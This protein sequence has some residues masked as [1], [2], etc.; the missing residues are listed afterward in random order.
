LLE[1]L[2]DRTMPSVTI[3]PTNNN[4]KGYTG[5]DYN[6]SGGYVPPDTQGAA[7]PSNYVETV[8]QT[9]A[10][11]SPKATGTTEVS[12]PLATFFASLPPVDGFGSYSDPVVTYDDN[13][14]GPAA[15]NGRF[16]IGDQNI[17][18]G[19]GAGVFDIAISKSSSPTT[20]T[21]TDWAFYQITTTE[22]NYFNDYPGN[23]GF[24]NDA[25]VFTLNMFSLTG[26]ANH[27]EVNAVSINDLLSG[28]PQNQLHHTQT[29]V[30]DFSL[31]PATEHNAAAGAPEWLI[32]QT[33]DGG[34]INVYKMQ[35]LLTTPSFSLTKLAVN[36]Y[37][38]VVNYPPLQP[39][40][41][42]ITTNIDSRIQKA[43]LEGN[44]LVATHPV[45]LSST[46][47][48]AQWYQIDVSSGTPSLH[49][50]GDVTLGNNTYAYY[51]AIDINPAGNIGM[52]FM[53]SGTGSGQYMSVYVTGRTSSDAT[54]TMETPVLVPAGT[55]QANYHDFSSTGRG[56]DLGG[57][58]IDPND[59]SFWATNEFA[60]TESTA[61][62]GTA[63]A[64]FSL[65]SALPTADLSVTNIGPSQVTAGKSSTYTITLAN[66]GPNTA[67]SL[68]L[69]D[70][71]P[72][73]GS[74]VSITPQAGNQDTFTLAQN[75]N[76]V[77]E[78]ATSVPSGHSDSFVLVVAVAS[79]LSNGSAFDDTASVSSNNSDPTPGDNTSTVNSTVVNNTQQADLG[80][81]DSAI[82]S[83]TEGN[84]VTYTL[85]VT[86]SGPNNATGVVLTDAFPSVKFISA[87]TSQGTF[88]QSGTTV[89]FNMGTI[90]AGQ[91]ATAHVVGQFGEDGTVTNSASVTSSVPD[92]N[93]NNNSAS[94]PTSVTEPTISLSGTKVT[95]VKVNNNIIVATFSHAKGVEPPNAFIA[96]INWG[97]GTS[98][99]GTI[100]QNGIS[101]YTVRGSHTY[102]TSGNHTITT[103]VVEASNGTEGGDAPAHGDSGT[104]ATPYIGSSLSV[105][106]NQASPAATTGHNSDNSPLAPPTVESS[107][108]TISA[109]QPAPGTGGAQT[110]AANAFLF[111][112]GGN[113]HRFASDK[114]FLLLAGKPRP[115]SR[116]HV[117][118]SWRSAFKVGG[119]RRSCATISR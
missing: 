102:A 7:G 63:I 74:L 22:A 39:D 27:V 71:I 98:S 115:D 77:T 52:T 29:D 90:V 107:A 55:G 108:P 10:I 113:R 21:S 18:S 93:P 109:R 119:S 101:Y 79:S 54:G 61:N 4:G 50:Q 49:Q 1:A 67:Q 91:H 59:Q 26:G 48:A 2:E 6:Q 43:A 89:T 24:N 19:T 14:I 33:G 117:N 53:D 34:H 38:D 56:G 35:N 100:T 96:T 78:T 110:S 46:Q 37:T 60:N 40:G 69:T 80:V 103:T 36:A 118:P 114:A 16:I 70:T 15:N 12:T 28:V 47:D 94:A 81:T 95:T 25:L 92:P 65:S 83:S 99:A 42:P 105:H 41:T 30:S 116:R 64:N 44:T 88:V 86:N 3:A 51:P 8:N 111:G 106:A 20:L 68:V 104:S 58:N 11:Y 76:T 85:T 45:A 66:Q 5:L 75:G 32:S 97:D 82:A 87:S 84:N 73:G 9:I 31:R 17:D 23:L 72:T 13:I 62:W 57:I 112:S